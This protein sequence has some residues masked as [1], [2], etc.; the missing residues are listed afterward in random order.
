MRTLRLLNIALFPAMLWPA[1]A[2]AHPKHLRPQP[3]PPVVI[4][5]PTTAP[6]LITVDANPAH[7]LN[8]F[9]PDTTFGA[10]VDGVPFHAVP[11][12][13]TPSNIQQMLGAGFGPVSYRLYTELSVQDWHWNPKGTFSEAGGRGYWTSSDQP[14]NEIVDSFGYRL[15]RRGFTHDQGNDDNYSRLDDGDLATFWKSNPYLTKAYTGDPDADHPQWVLYDLG[16]N[17]TV[18]A[19]KIWWADPYAVAYEIQYWTG[20]DPTYDAGNG[21]WVTFPNGKISNGGGGTVT[22]SLGNTRRKERFLRIVMSQSSG[23]CTKHH[24]SDPRDCVGYAIDEAGFGTIEHGVFTDLVTH[25]PN[26]KQTVTYASSVDPWHE[27]GNRV[28]DQ[29]QPGL[30]IVFQ[31]GVTRG[32]PATVPI[33]MMYSTPDNAAAEIRYLEARGYAIAR[34]EMGEE[35]D[36]Q[37]VTPEDDAALYA[38]FADALH[39]VDPKLQLG[40]PVFE[41]DLSDVKAWRS[42]E[43]PGRSWTKRFVAYLTAHNR[44]ADLGFFSFE[45]Y[46]FGTCDD[47]REEANLLRE[48]HLVS[49]IVSVWRHDNLPAGL[50]MY[51]TETNYSANETDAAQQVAGALWYAE[52]MGSLLST[53]ASGAFYYEYEP[54]PLSPSY[55]CHGWGTYGVLEGNRN[56][57]AQEPLSQYFAAQMLTQSWSAPG[58]ATQMLYPALIANGASWIAAYPLARSDGQW[59]LLLVNRDFTNTH[60]IQVQFNTTAGPAWFSGNVTQT[61]F[62]PSQYAWIA[63]GKHSYPSPDGPQSTA[64]VSGGEGMQYSLPPESLTVLT[65]N[66]AP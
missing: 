22:L 1:I 55:P 63:S 54:I 25:A 59:S 36:G 30:D 10:G 58:D 48:P 26:Q 39:D 64:T 56:Y 11:K 41:S 14:G 21:D 4:P 27:A 40:G 35:P 3:L 42:S 18:N 28:H 7:V 47:G 34:V 8:S 33:P 13:Y 60:S 52:L 66:V 51:I 2:D 16:K 29:E 15:P 50:P 6:Y 62:G 19:A 5:S 65:G 37:F 45:H 31:S 44:L 32:I 43:Y 24:R 61:G 46:P 53:G 9:A 20:D 12:I 23:S 57:K 49:N 38:Q 17:E